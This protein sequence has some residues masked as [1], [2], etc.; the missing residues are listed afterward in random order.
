MGPTRASGM[1]LAHWS[2]FYASRASIRNFLLN[3]ADPPYAAAMHSLAYNLKNPMPAD[4]ELVARARERLSAL[5]LICREAGVRFVLLIPPASGGRNDL[6]ASAAQLEKVN[7]YYPFPLGTLGREFF[8][9]DG[10]HLN[11]KGAA[12]FTKA[13]VSGIRERILAQPLNAET[14]AQSRTPGARF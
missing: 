13:L 5:D 6:L 4:D 3:K 2:A 1:M 10:A 9:A 14:S 11:E 12:I 8:R 7:Y